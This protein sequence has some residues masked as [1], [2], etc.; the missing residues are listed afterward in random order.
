MTQLLEMFHKSPFL[1]LKHI[2]YFKIYENILTKYK[3][4]KIIFVEIGVLNGGSLFMWRKFLGKKSR[5]IGI[6]INPKAKIFEKH[7]FEIFI[8]DQSD[9]GFWKYFFKKIGKVDI[10]L[11]DGGHTNKQQIFTFINCIKKIKDN[12]SL[13]IEDTHASYQRQFG[14]P[15]RYSFI[16]FAKKT[17]DDINSRFSGLKKFARSYSKYVY[18]ICFFESIVCFNINKSLCKKNYLIKN[19]G[20]NLNHEDLRYLNKKNNIYKKFINYLSN[21]NFNFILKLYL[22]IKNK[23]FISKK[24]KHYFY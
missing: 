12:G 23:F 2:N 16:N 5:I 1:S 13:I 19:K 21:S 24:I 3:K 6:D 18:S 9:E 10:I 4:K 14:N 20:I 7:G 15:Q 22:I 11:D 17:I 8:G